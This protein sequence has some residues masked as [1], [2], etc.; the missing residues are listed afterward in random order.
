MVV[1]RAKS[2][3][4]RQGTRPNVPRQQV[5]PNQQ[6][7]TAQTYQTPQQ[8]YRAAQPN[9]ARPQQAGQQ[10]RTVQQMG[11]QLRQ[12][13]QQMGQQFRQVGQ[14]MN[15]QA[16]PAQ[17]R[18][19]AQQGNQRAQSNYAGAR[20][21]GNQRAQSN[22]ILARATANVNENERDELEM[23][24]LEGAQTLVNAIDIDGTSALM[25]EVNDLMIMGYQ[26]DLSFERDF[27]AEGVEMLN[28]YE[29]PTEN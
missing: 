7:R 22:D 17:G 23:Q 29:L 20:Q 26:A 28:S 27:V 8:A 15:Q 13:G 12:A 25:K 11:Q 16:R 21:Q 14:R 1:S 6:S 18:Q 4:K 19:T 10:A 3:Q 24:M 9:Y 5:R 2:A